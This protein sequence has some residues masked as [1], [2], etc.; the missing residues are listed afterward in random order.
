[1]PRGGGALYPP[2]VGK[3]V[4]DVVGEGVQRA[5]RRLLLRG[6][7]AGACG[8]QGFRGARLQEEQRGVPSAR[9]A[10]RAR[11][12]GALLSANKAG[13]TPAPAPGTK[14]GLAA[15]HRSSPSG[16]G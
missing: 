4:V 9:V 5:H 14:A 1:M 13:P 16:G 7:A 6:V 3:A 8:I 10:G 2:C 15:P 11:G 12:P